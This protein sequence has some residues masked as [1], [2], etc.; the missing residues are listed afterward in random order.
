M[1]WVVFILMILITFGCSWFSKNREDAVELPP[2]R[3]LQSVQAKKMAKHEVGSLWS[4][5]S[6]WNDVYSPT[7]TRQPG[8]IITIRVTDSLKSR[9]AQLT[10][11]KTGKSLA[12]LK[13]GGERRDSQ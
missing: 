5:D 12:E 13:N 1:K 4:E 2:P 3:I 9:V 8:D 10:A 7:T 11:A 6:K